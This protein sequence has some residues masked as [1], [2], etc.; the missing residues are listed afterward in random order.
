MLRPHT[1]ET[2]EKNKIIYS[3]K[4]SSVPDDTRRWL[5]LDQ[6]GNV[7]VATRSTLAPRLG[8]E[9]IRECADPRKANEHAA[10]LLGQ[11]EAGPA[12]A[13]WSENARLVLRCY[14]LAAGLSGADAATVAEWA[15]E[16]SNDAP[17][18]VLHEH[19]DRVPAWWLE[20]FERN[21]SASADISE[22]TRATIRHMLLAAVTAE[23]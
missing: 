8:A 9:A 12:S 21:T 15:A 16:P 5:I 4:V 18:R 2:T 14:L 13:F 19:V 23:R 10:A 6:E 1:P 20:G 11:E 3:A 22:E 7:N 17:R